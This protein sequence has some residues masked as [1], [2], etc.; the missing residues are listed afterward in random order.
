MFSELRENDLVLVRKSFYYK[1]IDSNLKVKSEKY[2]RAEVGCVLL[3]LKNNFGA[4]C[5]NRFIIFLFENKKIFFN[6]SGVN[7]ILDVDECF[8]LL[9]S[10]EGKS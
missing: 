10:Q 8:E 7:R 6:S 3:V 1:F 9:Y 5:K 4:T 2:K